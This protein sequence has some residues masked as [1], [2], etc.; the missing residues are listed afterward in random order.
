MGVK[1]A[2]KRGGNA[3]GR[4]VRTEFFNIERG[5][6]PMSHTVRFSPASRAADARGVGWESVDA[7]G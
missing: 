2:S 4:R 3:G 1:I 7:D 6:S 5:E